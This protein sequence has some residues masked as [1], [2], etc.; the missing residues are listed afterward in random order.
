MDDKE[1]KSHFF[2]RICLLVDISMDIAFKML[3]FTLSNVEVKFNNWNLKWKLFTAIKAPF[4]TWRVEL[5]RKKEFAVATFDSENEI[6]VIYVAFSA[7]FEEIY[8]FQ[9]T[10]IA[11]LK[12]DETFTTVFPEYYDIAN[13]FSPKLIAKLWEHT[14]IND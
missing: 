1:K 12:V 5:L 2:E 8:L 11:L 13:D 3:F 14:R 4:I 10:Q 9:K 7:I 6:F